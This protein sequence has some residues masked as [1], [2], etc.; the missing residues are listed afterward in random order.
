MP[1]LADKSRPQVSDNNFSLIFQIFTFRYSCKSKFMAVRFKVPHQILF[2]PSFCR[3]LF[4]GTPRRCSY[5]NVGAI[6]AKSA[7]KKLRCTCGHMYDHSKI[8]VLNTVFFS[9]TVV[10]SEV[11]LCPQVRNQKMI[12]YLH[13]CSTTRKIVC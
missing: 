12:L 3:S 10:C 8:S 13:L 1:I 11:V 7:E 2:A 4:F 5:F 9:R 6:F